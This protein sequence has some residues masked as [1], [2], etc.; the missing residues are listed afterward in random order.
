M[1]KHMIYERLEGLTINVEKWH[2]LVK[3]VLKKYND[4]VHSTTGLTPN[5]A[6]KDEITDNERDGDSDVPLENSYYFVRI[7]ACNSDR[8]N[9]STVYLYRMTGDHAAD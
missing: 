5:E 1:L 6:R 7:D 8:S 2:E 3:V 4:T 9:E